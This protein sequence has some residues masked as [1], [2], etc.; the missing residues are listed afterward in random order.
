MTVTRR[1]APPARHM[2]VAAHLLY[3]GQQDPVGRDPANSSR[4]GRPP[5]PPDRELY[6]V[7]IRPRPE[8]FPDEGRARRAL[9]VNH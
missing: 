7:W 8:L 5:I 4:S 2:V 1:D 6:I 3:F 9:H